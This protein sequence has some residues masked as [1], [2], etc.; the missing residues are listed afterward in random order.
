MSISVRCGPA[1]WAIRGTLPNAVARHLLGG[2]YK[3]F[4][5]RIVNNYCDA[6]YLSITLFHLCYC[7][8]IIDIIFSALQFAASVFTSDPPQ[9]LKALM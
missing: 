6:L 5:I 1:V 8:Y 9:S 2:L 7:E 4:A 3:Q